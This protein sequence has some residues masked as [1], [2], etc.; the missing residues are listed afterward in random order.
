MEFGFVINKCASV[1]LSEN[2]SLTQPTQLYRDEHLALF[3]KIALSYFNAFVNEHP[4]ELR[5]YLQNLCTLDVGEV[6]KIIASSDKQDSASYDEAVSTLLH[7]TSYY[8]NH[9]KLLK[10]CNDLFG[11]YNQTNELHL[12]NGALQDEIIEKNDVICNNYETIIAQKDMMCNQ[13]DEII[14][15]M[16]AV[17]KKLDSAFGAKR[18]VEEKQLGSF[19]RMFEKL[20]KQYE[21]RNKISACAN[22]TLI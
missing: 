6:C 14:F 8:K 21:S 12:R 13:R 5:V 11:I 1:L 3:S 18:V 7:G 10:V 17:I 19:D 16:Y 15:K 20:L 2:V 22:E 4:Q 9:Q